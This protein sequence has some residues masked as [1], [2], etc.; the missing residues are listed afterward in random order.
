MIVRWIDVE[1]FF[2]DGRLQ[3]L[4]RDGLDAAPAGAD[5]AL[6]ADELA[7]D[8]AAVKHLDAV[9]IDELQAGLSRFPAG[10]S[11]T[12][13]LPSMSRAHWAMSKW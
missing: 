11:S 7:V 9:G 12:G 3:D 2:A 13:P 10:R 1:L 6:V 5:G 4:V 8:A